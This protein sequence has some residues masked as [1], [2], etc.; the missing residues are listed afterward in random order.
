MVFANS[1]KVSLLF[2]PQPLHE[3]KRMKDLSVPKE[4]IIDAIL[5]TRIIKEALPKSLGSNIRVAIIVTRKPRIAAKK[6][7]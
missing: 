2:S 3:K 6:L 5:I 7:P 4:I 1:D